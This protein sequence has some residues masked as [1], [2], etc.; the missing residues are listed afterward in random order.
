ML[1]DRPTAAQCAYRITDAT[2]GGVSKQC[3]K[4]GKSRSGLCFIVLENECVLL[5]GTVSSA[6]ALKLTIFSQF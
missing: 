3:K 4:Q 2:A 5:Y 6:Q 1:R